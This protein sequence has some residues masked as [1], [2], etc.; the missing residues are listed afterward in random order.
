MEL[1][2]AV[3]EDV[4]QLI[5]DTKTHQP[6]KS[7]N[8]PEYHVL[9]ELF[10]DADLAILGADWPTYQTY[11]QMIRKEYSH[12]PHEAYCAGRAK[13]L[14]SL[15]AKPHIFFTALFRDRFEAQAR[16]NTSAE[17]ANLLQSKLL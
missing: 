4:A 13:V 17:V 2:A 7:M 6:S 12:V 1:H 10:L 14:Q 8:N 9:C 3:V 16:E 5:L 11:A 15:T